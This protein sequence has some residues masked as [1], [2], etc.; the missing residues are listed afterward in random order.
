MI[1][2]THAAHPRGT[3][4]AYSDNA[5]VME[6]ATVARFYPDRDGRLRRARARRRTR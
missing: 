1:R 4:V 6:G 2:D 5:A 3:V